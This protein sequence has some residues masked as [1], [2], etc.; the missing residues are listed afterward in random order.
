M[1]K[2]KAFFG[3][4]TLIVTFALIGIFSIGDV[5]KP[6]FGDQECDWGCL[7]CEWNGEAFECVSTEEQGTWCFC[8]EKQDPTELCNLSWHYR[9]FP[10]I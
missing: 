8:S 6:V 3:I 4:S 7:M 10:P 1:K 9:C 2:K 5:V